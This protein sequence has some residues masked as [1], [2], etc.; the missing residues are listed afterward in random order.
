M[1]FNPE[2]ALFE[3]IETMPPPFPAIAGS[4]ES[5]PVFAYRLGKFADGATAGHCCAPC[6]CKALL[7]MAERRASIRDSNA[8]LAKGI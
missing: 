1:Q 8:Q 6:A 4:A 2:M 7:E 3:T 5:P